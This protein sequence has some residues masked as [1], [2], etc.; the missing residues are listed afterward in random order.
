MNLDYQLKVGTKAPL[1]GVRMRIVDV[2][3]QEDN[4]LVMVVQGL[5]RVRVLARTQKEPYARATV[6]LLFV[7]ELAAS[8]YPTATTQLMGMTLES[9]FFQQDER[10]IPNSLSRLV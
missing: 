4:R 8:H 10:I 2:K 1:T 6:L 7:A 3:R 5:S 9:D